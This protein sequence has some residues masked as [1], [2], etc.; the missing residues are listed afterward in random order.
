MPAQN[1][2]IVKKQFTRGEQVW[3]K[4]SDLE[5]K[6]WKTWEFDYTKEH[7]KTW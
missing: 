3:F 1:I 4:V 6:G 7:L 5:K 2:H